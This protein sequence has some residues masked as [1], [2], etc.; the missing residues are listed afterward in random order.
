MLSSQFIDLI[1]L[2]IGHAD[3]HIGLIE[4]LILLLL[5]LLVSSLYLCQFLFD[6]IGAD[7][8]G[9]HNTTHQ[10]CRHFHHIDRRLSQTLLIHNDAFAGRVFVVL[11]TILCIF[12]QALAHD[13]EVVGLGFWLGG[14]CSQCYR[15]CR[16]C[17]TGSG[18]AT[19]RVLLFVLILEGRYHLVLY[20]GSDL[21]HAQHGRFRHSILARLAILSYDACQ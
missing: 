18:V 5:L 11:L 1:D 2:A 21:A 10:H 12:Y 4:L 7:T 20:I 6:M 14:S 16:D 19:G 8:D 3:W 9:R 17:N 13:V 15:L